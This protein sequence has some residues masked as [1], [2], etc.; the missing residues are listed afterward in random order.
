MKALQ[1]NKLSI[2]GN[3]TNKPTKNSIASKAKKSSKADTIGNIVYSEYDVW[4]I[5]AELHNRKN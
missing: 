4:P 5:L 3:G 2:Q 1:K